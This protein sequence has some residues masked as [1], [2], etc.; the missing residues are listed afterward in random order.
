[1]KFDL[2]K[3]KK[4][5]SHPFESIAVAVA[6]SPRLESVLSEAKRIKDLLGSSLLLVHIGEKTKK[7]ES[8]LEKAMATVGIKESD[9]TI[10]WEPGSPVN[11]IL[12]LC[13]Y[14]II[15]L[16]ILGALEKENILKF[17][18]GSFARTISR[19]AKCSVLLLTHPSIA[20]S[21]VKKIIVSGVDSPKTAHTL[22]TSVYLAEK[23]GVKDITLVN[24][25][26]SDVMAMTMADSSTAPEAS[27]MKKEMVQQEESKLQGLIKNC[28]STS[29]NIEIKTIK[30]KSGY[31]AGKYARDRKADLLVINS[32]DKHM[33]ILDR[34][35]THDIEYIL[36]DLPCD[37]LIVHSRI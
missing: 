18:L 3:L 22:S 25:V 8:L 12:G 24:E 11:T 37:V 23:L 19:K 5:P 32:P 20:P 14:H 27:K 17:Y 6:F 9:A 1:M 13:K 36:A 31:A 30:G 21:K 16:L 35:F 28:K 10:L 29:V 15:D 2:S 33:G 4:R 7:K 26:E 34:I